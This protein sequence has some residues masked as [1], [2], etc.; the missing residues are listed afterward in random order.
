[1]HQIKCSELNFQNTRRIFAGIRKIALIKKNDAV[2]S[3]SS[4]AP[5]LVFALSSYQ[6]ELT[7]LN[8][9]LCQNSWGQLN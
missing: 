1:M 7:D 8:Q 4:Y 5:D 6:Q 9:V 2:E 3:T